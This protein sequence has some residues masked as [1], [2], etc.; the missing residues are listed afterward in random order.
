[1][2]NKEIITSIR[3]NMEVLNKRNNKEVKSHI[4][5]LVRQIGRLQTEDKELKL[6]LARIASDLR[7][8]EINEEKFHQLN[9]PSNPQILYSEGFYHSLEILKSELLPLLS[10]FNS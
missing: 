5:T 9:N 10:K 1:M 3:E 7:M 8:T 2:E 4:N 6:Q